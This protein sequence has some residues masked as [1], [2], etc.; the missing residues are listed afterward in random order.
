M[1]EVAPTRSEIWIGLE[2]LIG[3]DAKLAD[4]WAHGIHLLAARRWRELE[5]EVP[6]LLV[7]AEQRAAV[8]TIAATVL[9][10]RVRAAWDGPMLLFKGPEAASYYPAPT[11]RPYIDIDL[12]VPNP[13]EAQRALLAAGFEECEN[14]PWAFRFANSD[15]D[16]F[17]D[18]HHLRPIRWPG[19]PLNV[20]LHRR[21]SWPPW[22]PTP[23]AW[24]ADELFSVGVPSQAAVDGVLTL[25]R[26]HHALLLAAHSWVHSPLGRLG[27]LIDV[28][29]VSEGVDER[30]LT[31]V[32]E[33]WGMTRL[34]RT[35]I[36]A[37]EAVIV[38]RGAANTLALRTWARNLPSVR[39]R[40]VFETH[41]ERWLSC[42]SALPA[43]QAIR[44][45]SANL[46]M[47]LRPATHEPWRSKLGRTV[48]AI[49][50]A[51]TS[52]S[53]HDAELGHQGRQLT[54]RRRHGGDRPSKV[55]RAR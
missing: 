3:S 43:G 31:V 53:K 45:S 55:P 14:P 27:D 42:F 4:L 10:Q 28:A 29:V 5:L 49:R 1:T 34:W 41:L 2:R 11:L 19:L 37:M 32:A 54:V 40:T 8:A 52:K 21:P 9:L 16:L 20:E 46:L 51:F 39:E 33:R 18:R 7:E 17:A 12:L 50:N 24:S 44:V 30:E 23:F 25:P 38:G 13:E 36:E 35:M 22:M 15:V 26:A 47:D 6:P 48:R